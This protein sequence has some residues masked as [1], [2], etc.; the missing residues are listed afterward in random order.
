MH[1]R[2]SEAGLLLMIALFSLLTVR[3]AIAANACATAANAGDNILLNPSGNGD[4][5]QSPSGFFHLY[6]NSNG[7]ITGS[8]FN[9]QD[10]N[11]GPDINWAI[12]GG[13]LGNGKF[14]VIATYTGSN[15][16]GCVKSVTFTGTIAAPGCDTANVS[17]TN[18]QGANGSGSWTHACYVPSGETPSVFDHWGPPPTWFYPATA[19]FKTSMVTAISGFPT[20]PAYNWGGR[21]EA[22]T[23]P[24]PPPGADGC[25]Y[26]GSAIDPSAP[27][28]AAPQTV[29]S[30]AAYEDG[31]GDAD[32]YINYYRQKTRV[33]C[34]WTFQQ[35]MKT[36]CN[37]TQPPDTVYQTNTLQFLVGLTTVASLRGGASKTMIYGT[38]APPITVLDAV[39]NFLLD[40]FR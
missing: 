6:Q 23:F 5:W 3:V 30:S 21:T 9:S 40:L 38:P 10:R 7:A 17:W 27:A 26:P 4:D 20:G 25:Y 34:G 35:N 24:P 31:V 16:I 11:C 18:N 1:K 29:D 39:E 8:F 13:Y 19:T 14:T 22:E 12:S 36:D 32:D 37:A 28:A 2:R 15:K 33:P